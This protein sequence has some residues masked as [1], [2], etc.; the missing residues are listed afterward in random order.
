[1]EDTIDVT[2]NK[3]RTAEE[4]VGDM[5]PLEIKEIVEVIVNSPGNIKE[6]E[7][8]Y[9]TKY[10]HFVERYP[11]L[12]KMACKPDF[13]M[14][15][16]DYILGMMA[17]VNTNELSYDNATKEFGQKMFDTYVKPNLDKMKKK[18]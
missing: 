2:N 15:R 10:S 13:D 18:K 8:I 5:T 14:S 12:F 4:S 6:K 11:M 1:M 7:R 17:R 16:L 3:K 9:T